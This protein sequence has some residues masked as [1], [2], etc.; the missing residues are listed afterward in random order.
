MKKILFLTL[1]LVVV[2]SFFA[3]AGGTAGKTAEGDFLIGISNS[4]YGNLWREKMLEDMATVADFYIKKGWL[5]DTVVQQSGPDVQTQIQQIRNMI[6]QGVDL[7]TINPASASGLTGVIEEA[8]DVGIPSIVFDAELVG[9]DRKLALS[10]ASDKY[11]EMYG[12]TKYV[13]QKMGGKGD[14]VVMLGNAA[15]QPTQ[16][17]HEGVKGALKEFPGVKVLT[18][19][20]GEWNQATAEAVMN[21]VVA[22]YPKIDAVITVGSMGMGA[23][24][25]FQ[26][27]GRPLPAI[28]GDPT[29]E[30]MLFCDEQR[31]AGKEFIF[32]APANPPGIGGTALAIGVYM[33]HGYEFKDGVLKDNTYFYPV[34]TLVTN[35]NLDD[36]LKEY[37]G[38]DPATWISEFASDE[39]VRKLFK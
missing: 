21:D 1:I 16:K 26:N 17:R 33:L 8:K 7:I 34:K 6:N 15:Y 13:L 14:V 20:Y 18:T 27:A 19:V 5:K 37:A 4:L 2:C 3:F 9:E 39:E 11:V 12:A 30:F 29:V 31:K 36:Y 32:A 23:L 28:T 25:A 22:A 35:D 10:V 24:R 38:Q